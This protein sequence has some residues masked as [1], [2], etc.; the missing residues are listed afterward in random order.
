M[1]IQIIGE[2]SF[3]T[4]LNELL[5]PI[6]EIDNLADSVIL[7]VPNPRIRQPRLRSS[8][9]AFDKRMQRA[10]AEHRGRSS[11]YVKCDVDPSAIWPADTRRKAKLDPYLRRAAG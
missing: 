6:F 1:K 8:R 4:F 7:A 3:G 5:A 2:G 10:E 11:L 9:P